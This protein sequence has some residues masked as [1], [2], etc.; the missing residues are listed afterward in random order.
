MQDIKARNIIKLDLT[1]LDDR[2]ADYF[3]ICEADTSVQVKAIA[4]NIYRR[5]KDEM[6]M[7]PGHFEGKDGANWVLVDFFDTIAH[8]FDPEARDFYEIEELWGDA[9]IT[10][11]ADL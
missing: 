7:T 10:E 8:V 1:K 6:S 3:I 4:N 2:P 11:Y 5:V 9:R